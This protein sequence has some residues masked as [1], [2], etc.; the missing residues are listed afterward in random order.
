MTDFSNTESL[1]SDMENLLKEAH[2]LE[3]RDRAFFS[4]IPWTASL[5]ADPDFTNLPMVSRLAQSSGEDSFL[6]ETMNTTGT[7]PHLLAYY[8]NLPS[9]ESNASVTEVRW[10]LQIGNKL[11]GWP[12]VMHGGMQSFILDEIMAFMLGCSRRVPGATPLAMNTV[13]AELKVKYLRAFQTPGV[14]VVGARL[15][16]RDGRKLW[17]EA[18]VKNEAG[19]V[20]ANA[21]ALFLSIKPGTGPK[22]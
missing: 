8:R 22:I 6:A 9:D 15:T 16:K 7:I 10:L 3:A 19:V 12:G 5:M 11:N 18:E 20:L 1:S 2:N 13:T 4:S 14:V 17:T 21:E